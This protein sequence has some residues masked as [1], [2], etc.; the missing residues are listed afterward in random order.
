MLTVHSP[1]YHNY[2]TYHPRYREE[3][4]LLILLSGAMTL[5]NSILLFFDNE[6]QICTLNITLITFISLTPSKKIINQFSS[7]ERDE[8]ADSEQKFTFETVITTY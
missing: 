2:I 5:T 3:H 1:V 6:S 7:I 8:F 4:L